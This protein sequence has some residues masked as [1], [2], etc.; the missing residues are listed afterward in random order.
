MNFFFLLFHALSKDGC[1]NFPYIDRPL[2][3]GPH[4]GRKHISI[5]IPYAHGLIGTKAQAYVFSCLN[6]VRT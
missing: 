3:P 1:H 2:K 5:T 6:F 4:L